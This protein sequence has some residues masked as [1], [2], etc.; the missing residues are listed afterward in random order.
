VL[1]GLLIRLD[2]VP[3]PIV[4]K[5]EEL[6]PPCD[7]SLDELPTDAPGSPVFAVPHA[8]RP[9]AAATPRQTPGKR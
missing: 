5:P 3:V 8:M 6:P 7:P 1:V 4:L 2:V 9:H